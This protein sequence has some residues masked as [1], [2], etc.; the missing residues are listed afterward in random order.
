MERAKARK[1]KTEE[2]WEKVDK[3]E[4]PVLIR[5]VLFPK[6][7]WFR[8]TF[9][10]LDQQRL[11]DRQTQFTGGADRVPKT[12]SV[13]ET[14]SDPHRDTDDRGVASVSQGANGWKFVFV[15]QQFF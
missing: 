7:T 1:N 4:K 12:V 13:V 2:D 14:D 11:R 5:V 6:Q 9:C 3:I 10:E 8:G 15:G